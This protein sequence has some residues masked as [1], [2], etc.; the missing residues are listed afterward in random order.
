METLTQYCATNYFVQ[1]MT[2]LNTLHTNKLCLAFASFVL[3]RNCGSYTEEMEDT[4]LRYF[5]PCSHTTETEKVK[6]YM[7][8]FGVD[9]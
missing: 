9:C 3:I 2:H 1:T 4:G 8:E 7:M 6:K 5:V